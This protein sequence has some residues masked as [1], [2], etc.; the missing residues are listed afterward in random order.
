MPKKELVHSPRSPYIQSMY[1][2]T[3]SFFL[4]KKITRFVLLQYFKP[5]S[6]RSPYNLHGVH[7]LRG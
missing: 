7:G 3:L 5:R 6:S 4:E 2:L 1:G